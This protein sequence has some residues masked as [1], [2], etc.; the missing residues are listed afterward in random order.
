MERINT[1]LGPG[2]GTKRMLFFELRF[3]QRVLFCPDKDAKLDT[4]LFIR[5]LQTSPPPALLLHPLLDSGTIVVNGDR[6]M[7]ES[8]LNIGLLARTAIVNV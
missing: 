4:H 5:L 6:C 8:I 1:P 7:C 3:A 2:Q